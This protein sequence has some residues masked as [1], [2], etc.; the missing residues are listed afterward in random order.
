MLRSSNVPFYGRFRD[1]SWLT[2]VLEQRRRYLQGGLSTHLE[3]EFLLHVMTVHESGMSNYLSKSFCVLSVIKLF[4]AKWNKKEKFWGISNNG[5]VAGIGVLN[6]KET[7]LKKIYAPFIGHFY[8]GKYSFLLD[9]FW[10][11]RE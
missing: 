5:K 7:I 1:G 9:T 3:A 6:A 8:F 11:H 2:P 4:A 10:R